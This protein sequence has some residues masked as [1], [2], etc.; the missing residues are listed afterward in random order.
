MSQI[1][2]AV[3]GLVVMYVLIILI[4]NGFSGFKEGY[5]IEEQNLQDEKNVFQKLSE[6]NL[7]QGVNDLTLGIQ[8]LGKLANPLDLIGGLALSASGTLQVIGGIV[9]FPIEIFGVITGFYDNIIPPII[10][11][12]LGMLSVIVIGF[13]ILSAK[14]GWKI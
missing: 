10:P 13:V 14:I 7:I 1:R 2:N 12:L 11:Q 9:T 8:S 3:G 4:V 5:S 6:L